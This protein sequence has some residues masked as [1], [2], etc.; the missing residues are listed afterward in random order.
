MRFGS[1]TLAALSAEVTAANRTHADIDRLFQRFAVDI[2]NEPYI[3]RKA[4][5]LVR[6]LEDSGAADPRSGEAAIADLITIVLRSRAEGDE[7]NEL[8]DSLA[9]DGFRWDGERLLPS[10]PEP[11][12]LGPQI[13]A[14]EADLQAASLE[15]ASGHYREAY[16]SFT[17]GNWA[18]SN[19][20]LRS[21][22]ED[23]FVQLGAARTRHVRRDLT[24]AL[25]D[26]RTKGHLDHAE[27]QMLKAFW[28]GIQDNGPH[29][30]LSEEQEALFR[31]HVGT[32]VGRY[33]LH[34]L[35]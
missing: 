11:A 18:A 1:R 35:K 17:A 5:T 23:L 31:L 16:E 13:S 21:Y 26:L 24:A 27:E 3:N 25:Q 2:S 15:V 8:V 4:N 28:Q 19:G 33:L 6:A 10:S 7:Q 9:A 14:L 32:A 12:A 29:R 22:I 30:G 34:K 20:Q